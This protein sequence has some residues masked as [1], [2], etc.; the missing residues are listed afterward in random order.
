MYYRISVLCLAQLH[1]DIVDL[2]MDGAL[3]L[4]FTHVYA[5]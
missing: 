5:C 4:T 2:L 1:L 3:S